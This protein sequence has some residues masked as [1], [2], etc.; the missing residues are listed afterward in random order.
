MRELFFKRG[1]EENQN[2]FVKKGSIVNKLLSIIKEWRVRDIQL[3]CIDLIKILTQNNKVS[4]SR[5]L[6]GPLS[7]GDYKLRKSKILMIYKIR[8]SER[9]FHK[10][11]NPTPSKRM[12]LSWSFKVK[13]VNFW[14]MGGGGADRLDNEVTAETIYSQ[15]WRKSAKKELQWFFEFAASKRFF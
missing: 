12:F 2:L 11:E 15:N 6:S 5:L 9:L 10:T 14:W 3:S 13:E 7:F 8:I 1:H 4:Y